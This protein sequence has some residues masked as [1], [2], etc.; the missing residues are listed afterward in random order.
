MT[1]AGIHV[2]YD[3]ALGQYR[4]SYPVDG[5]V[6]ETVEERQRKRDY[7]QK[8]AAIGRD[9]RHYV[10]AYHEPVRKLTSLLGLSELGAVMK[11]LPYMRMDHAGDLY[12]GSTRMSSAEIAKAIGKAAR[13][14][15]TLISTLVGCDILTESREGKR[16]VYGVNPEYHAIGRTLNDGR[17][18]KVY[19]TKLRSDVRD[20]TVQAA[21]LL[22]CMIPYIHYKMLYLCT[23]PDDQNENALDHITQVAFARIVGVDEQTARRGLRELSKHGFIMRAEAFGAVVIRMN[24]DVMYRKEACDDEHTQVVRY[25]FAQNKRA[26]EAAFDG[27]DS[28]LPF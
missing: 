13:W 26:M 11:L 24:P 22:Y 21:G 20:L 18:T 1:N 3:E 23:N 17:Y 9:Q 25:A 19:Q 8:T 28:E 4:E 5:Y 12:Y 15:S 7:A 14:T 16:K 6:H 2:Y 27:D 10:Q